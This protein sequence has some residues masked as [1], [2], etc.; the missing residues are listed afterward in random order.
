[1]AQVELLMQ[2]GKETPVLLI[3]D[4]GAE[5]DRKRMHAFM[6]W[7]EKSRCQTLITMLEP[8]ISENERLA[9]F[10]VEHGH[11]HRA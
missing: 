11:I 6:N 7:L 5:L 2:Q 4:V 9:V 1:L 3:D 8:D 10:H